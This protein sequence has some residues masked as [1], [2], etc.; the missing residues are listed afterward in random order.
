MFVSQNSAVVVFWTEDSDGVLMVS[1][2]PAQ[3]TH[4]SV[5]GKYHREFPV[6][7]WALMLIPR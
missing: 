7:N 2:S 6:L 5:S 3:P 4:F 1:T